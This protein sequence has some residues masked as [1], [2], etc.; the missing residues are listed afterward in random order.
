MKS[1]KG[2]I[3]TSFAIVLTILVIMATYSYITIYSISNNV[4][5]ITSNDMT[6]L[7]SSNSMTF[8]VANRAKIARDYVLFNHQEFK[9]QFLAETEDAIKTEKVLQDTITSGR[10]SKQIEAALKEANEKTTKWRELVTNEMIPLYDNG[11][12]EAAIK[13]MEEKCLP[14]SKDAIEAWTKVVEIQ[15]SITK[16]STEEMKSSAEQSELVIIILSILTI[17]TAIIIALYNANTISKAITLVVERL[18]TI[19][20]GDLRSESFKIKSKDEIGR[21]VKASN[22]MTSNLKALMF[23]IAGTSDQLAASSE[24]FSASAEQ[25]SSSAE[26]VTTSIQNIAQGA[27][28]SSQN[29][30]KCVHAINDMSTGVQQIAES[31]A[32]VVQEAQNTTKQAIE[33]NTLIQKAVSQMESIQTSVGITSKLVTNL[34]E[35]SK[36]IGQIIEVITGIADQTNLLALN[37]AIEAARAGEHGR[38]F[39]IVAD[40][41]R[42]LAE[43]SKHSADRISNLIGQ[44]QSDTKVAVESM[45]QGTK[46]VE[47]GTNVISEAGQAFGRI[48]KSIQLVS[49]KIEQA[50]SSAEQ[51]AGSTHQVNATIVSLAEIAQNASVD[52]QNVATAAEEQLA[53]MQEVAASATS[54]SSLAEELQQELN[55]FKF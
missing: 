4:E 35:H 26:Q 19:A 31:S 42:K 5:D 3:L 14:Y 12:K 7:E 34:G 9:E 33:G 38:G 43:Q 45:A 48:L 8:S 47:V 16:A 50:S 24:Q 22:T 17:V 27:E 52:S 51:M 21:L 39:A 25:S 30:N 15:N 18:E 23:R 32:D 54:L 55:K 20:K 41:V 36:E 37:A 53:A 2:K 46:E 1:I 49:E 44:I 6:F 28:T 40:E 11:N 29:T 10:I 13:L